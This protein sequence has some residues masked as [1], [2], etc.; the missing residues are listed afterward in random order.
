MANAS[1]SGVKGL[2]KSVSNLRS[3]LG[4]GGGSV[5]FCAGISYDAHTQLMV[6][7]RPS[8]KHKSM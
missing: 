2:L 1:E 5:R 8:L 4:G 6:L 7:P 3:L